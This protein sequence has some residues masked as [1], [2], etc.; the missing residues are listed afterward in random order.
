MNIANHT[1]SNRI[2]IDN[3]N[4]NNIR[5][6]GGIIDNNRYRNCTRTTDEELQL[7]IQLAQPILT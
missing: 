6:H 7:I 4:R 2:R 3:D 5:N 1:Y